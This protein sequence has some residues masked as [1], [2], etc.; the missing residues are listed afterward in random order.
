MFDCCDSGWLL[1][2]RVYSIRDHMLVLRRS[3]PWRHVMQRREA[4]QQSS[5]LVAKQ[6]RQVRAPKTHQKQ[7]AV[8]ASS[9]V[10]Y[11]VS[12]A[13]RSCSQMKQSYNNYFR[14]RK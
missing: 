10:S 3:E 12:P 7:H 6:R 14:R 1:L 9:H 11:K 5:N 2:A 8:T 4:G 13:A